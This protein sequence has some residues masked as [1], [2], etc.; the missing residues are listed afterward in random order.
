MVD[1]GPD[2][3]TDKNIRHAFLR[4]VHPA[5]ADADPPRHLK[6]ALRW[7]RRRSLPLNSITDPAIVRSRLPPAHARK[8]VAGDTFR[9]RRLG[10][11]TALEHAVELEEIPENP[12]KRLK[13]KRTATAD[14]IDPRVVVTHAQGRELLTA[15]SYVGSWDRARGRRLVAFF[16]VLYH[17]GLRPAEAV[18]LREIDCYPPEKGWGSL[19]LARPCRSP[20]KSGSKP[21]RPS[22]PQ[23]A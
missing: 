9:R 14:R 19:I 11:N 18:A 12:L 10:L 21:A 13:A 16:A 4:A 6:S 15:V 5:N 1:D 20:P 22:R 23:A 2:R 8:T 3:P 7:L 17:A